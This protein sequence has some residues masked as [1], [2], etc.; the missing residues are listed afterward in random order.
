MPFQ[1]SKNVK[2]DT[3]SVL[4]KFFLRPYKNFHGVA[5]YFRADAQSRLLY[6]HLIAGLRHEVPNWFRLYCF[7][8]I[9]PYILLRL[10]AFPFS[11]LRPMV[12]MR[13]SMINIWYMR[14]YLLPY[15][16]PSA[17]A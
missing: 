8:T 9:F 13:Y 3:S 1:R 14:S 12:Y 11:F 15:L 6:S 16:P 17:E 5:R 7:H 4:V 2:K 10:F